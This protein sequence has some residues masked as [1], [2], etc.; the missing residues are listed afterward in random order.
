MS[1]DD[2]VFVGAGE[3]ADVAVIVVTYNS[4]QDVPDLLADLRRAASRR[5]IRAI[6]VDNQSTDGTAEVVEK[7]EDVILIR[8]DGNLGYS[9]G[10]NCARPHVGRCSAVL[11]LNPD[12]RLRDDA[13]EIMLAALEDPR[14]GAVVPRMLDDD[15]STYPSLRRE[16]SIPAALG[17]AVMG[18]RLPQ[19]PQWMS[20]MV[21]RPTSYAKAHAVDWATGAAVMIRADVENATGDWNEE[22]FLYSEETDYF[23]RIR[24]GGHLVWYQPSAVV[25]HSGG[26]S[27]TSPVLASLMAVNRVRYVERH[28]GPVYATVFRSV[29]A[30]SEALRARDRV[31]RDS[32]AIVLN[33]H[34][35]VDLPK[36]SRA[37]DCQGAR[38]K[39]GSG[40]VI[41]PA[42]NEATV[43][44]NTIRP[45]SVAAKD[46]AIE[47]I[48]VCNGCT[49]GTADAARGVPGATVLEIDEA[50]KVAALNTGDDAATLWPRMYLDADIQV[51]PGAVARVFDVLRSGGVLAARPSSRYDTAGASRLVRSYYRSR[52][53][54]PQFQHALWGAGAYALSQEG[55]RRIGR[56][57]NLVA[58]D[59][60]VD[61]QFAA[62]EKAVVATEPTTVVTPRDTKS[63]ITTLR[64][65]YRGKTEIPGTGSGA[66]ALQSVVRAIRGPRSAMDA[67]VYVAISLAARKGASRA[68][69]P[70]W[71]RDES[72]RMDA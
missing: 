64:R 47:L 51:T 3:Q 56:F 42:H 46:E 13:I 67:C 28:H 35:W 60:W 34:R 48:I 36:A 32:L 6:V 66:R 27:G 58:D 61:R 5:S 59:L 38:L 25:Q 55:H 49:D 72:S 50:S 53:K 68:G 43:I 17:D 37:L 20:E 71:E 21:F 15:E 4:A 69:T 14:V 31:H 23:R 30:L 11:V 33:R 7:Q 26:G 29:V 8:A 41:V 2:G 54:I 22:F 40:S 70:V 24:E 16:P 39:R 44:A 65:V 52:Q 45:L 10:V 18:S 19:R 1:A 57:P 12:L 62:D 63:L 9:G